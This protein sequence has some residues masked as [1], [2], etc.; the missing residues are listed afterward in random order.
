MAASS[1]IVCRV[2]MRTIVVPEETAT[3]P[4]TLYKIGFFSAFAFLVMASLSQPEFRTLPLVVG[5][6][7]IGLLL[8]VAGWMSFQ[9][10][11]GAATLVANALAFGER[12][13][14]VIDTEM[15]TAPRAAVRVLV[16]GQHEVRDTVAFSVSDVVEPARFGRTSGGGVQIPFSVLLPADEASRRSE[17]I[18]LEARTSWWPFGWGATFLIKRTRIEELLR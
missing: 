2:A 18:R 9:N 13:E 1:R 11:Y 4:I 16:Y 8:L 10:R 12:F 6:L 3:T 17:G 15:Q 7:I 5:G 14:G